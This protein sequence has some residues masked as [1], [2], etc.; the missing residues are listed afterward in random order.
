MSSDMDSDEVNSISD[1]TEALQVVQIIKSTY[2][3]LM[4]RKFRPH[5]KTLFK[6]DSTGSSTPS[7]LKLPE[8]VMELQ[9]F[10]Y[11]SKTSTQ[12]NVNY[13]PIVYMEV[14]DF[15]LYTNNR[16][17]DNSSVDLITDPS[18]TKIKIVNDTAP[19]YWTSFDDEY[20]VCDSYDSTI[21]SNLQNS[22]TQL[23][24]YRE[25]SLILTDG[26]IPD[27]PSE[28]FPFL[29]SEAKKHCLVKLK[30]VDINDP[31]YREEAAR[32]R[33]QNSWQQRKKWRTHKQSKY[34]NFGRK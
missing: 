28:S 33:N 27:L 15:L 7:H 34:P 32:S 14:I 10:N 16:N 13:K 9:M 31:A 23:V 26:T 4:T 1:T 2:E 30:Q 11:D 21:E 24:G 12:T 8:N 5:L 19:Q 20:L 18:G 29:L 3:D 17:T 6:L 22:K 25:P